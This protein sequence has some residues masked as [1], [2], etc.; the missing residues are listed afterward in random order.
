M[1][2]FVTVSMTDETIRVDRKEHSSDAIVEHLDA[3]HRVVVTVSA[4]GIEREV[5]LRKNDGEYICDTGLKLMSYDDP[6]EMKN[7]IERL[8]L[9]SGE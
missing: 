4:L 8:R 6:G 2:G 1:P 7:C 9:A 5:T 3:G